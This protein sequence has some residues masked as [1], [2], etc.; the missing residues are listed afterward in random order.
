MGVTPWA[1]LLPI[2]VGDFFENGAG[3]VDRTQ[4]RKRWAVRDAGGA[5]VCRGQCGR[6]PGPS[7]SG[8]GAPGE[9][10]RRVGCRTAAPF[11]SHRMGQ[12]LGPV[13]ALAV[14]A[15]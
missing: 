9:Q 6:G 5:D 12:I 14:L 13:Y 8:S 15:I 4:N 1:E 7:G 11:R 10:K 2:P 3:W